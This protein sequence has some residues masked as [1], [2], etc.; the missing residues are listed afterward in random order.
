MGSCICEC[1]FHSESFKVH[2][3]ACDDYNKES[4]IRNLENE[5]QR[6]REENKN[7]NDKIQTKSC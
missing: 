6:L 1:R 4:K 5:V 7:L 3:L 2:S